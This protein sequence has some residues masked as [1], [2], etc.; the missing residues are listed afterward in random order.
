MESDIQREVLRTFFG[1]GDPWLAERFMEK[2]CRVGSRKQSQLSKQS[3]EK[4]QSMKTTDG[5][6]SDSETMPG[7]CSGYS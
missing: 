4:Q 1:P 5:R 7:S 3:E 6:T 2:E